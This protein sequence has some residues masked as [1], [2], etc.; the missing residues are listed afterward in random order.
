MGTQNRTLALK[1]GKVILPDGI[2]EDVA[3]LCADGKITGIVPADAVPA[4][5]DV[6]DAGGR[7][8]APGFV[9]I[10][11]HG[12]GDYDFMDGTPDAFRGIARIHCEHGTTAL[13]PTTLTSSDEELF[14]LFDIYRQVKA[15]GTTGADFIGMNLEGPYFSPQYAG[16][17]D[18][19][20]LVNP[21]PEHYRKILDM[22]GDV[23]ARWC[24]APELDG[25]MDFCREVSSRG[26][27]V[28]YGHTAAEC[29]T[30]EEAFKL[31]CTHATHLY[32]AMSSIVRINAYRHSGAV[33]ASYLLDDATVE[34]IADGCHLPA[35]LLKYV[36][37][38]KGSRKTAL[39]TDA[40]RA[41]GMPEGEYLLGSATDGQRVIVEDGVA[42]MPDRTMFA[43]SVATTDRLVRTMVQLAGVSMEEAVRMMTETPAAIIGAASKGS[44]AAGKDAD[45]VIFDDNVNV[46]KTIIGG[47]TVYENI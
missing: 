13:T 9:D 39:C 21:R 27:L 16:A 34:I 12:G 17:Q 28:S 10:H 3:V 29:E 6:I 7:Y 43:G 46:Y 38:F 47:K 26:I 5:A 15:E 23:I 22:G 19:R 20:Y 18:P 14:R 1:G 35:S 41:A 31:G 30:V 25:A 2:R 37:K 33:E 36:Y 44:I 32:C 42:K 4:D 45:F 40:I 8:I 11:V 24:V